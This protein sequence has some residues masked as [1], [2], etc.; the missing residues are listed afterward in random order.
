[1]IKITLLPTKVVKNLDL[2]NDQILEAWY[3]NERLLKKN[4]LWYPGLGGWVGG[5]GEEKKGGK[6]ED[7][8]FRFCSFN[9]YD[10]TRF[11]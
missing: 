5:M 3:I 2:V 11:N 9:N 4:E 7:D 1:M 8:G 10:L 6:R